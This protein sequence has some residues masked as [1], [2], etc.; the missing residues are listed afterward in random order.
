MYSM[1]SSS[2][3]LIRT[4]WSFNLTHSFEKWLWFWY[5]SFLFKGV[6]FS[7][8]RGSWIWIIENYF[9]QNSWISFASGVLRWWL[10]NLFLPSIW[11]F[12]VRSI[13]FW[14]TLS[15]LQEGDFNLGVFV[16]FP[17]L[18]WL[19]CVLYRGVFISINAIYDFILLFFCSICFFS[20]DAANLIWLTFVVQETKSQGTVL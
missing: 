12:V 2:Q 19:G 14:E 13:F 11:V 6:S 1:L 10:E 7:F 18:A 17:Q 16:G 5:L 9:C 15:C 3:P 20:H 4:Y 8:V